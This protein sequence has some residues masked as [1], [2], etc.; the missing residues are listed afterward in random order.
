M[1]FEIGENVTGKAQTINKEII[2]YYFHFKGK[3]CIKKKC[4]KVHILQIIHAIFDFSGHSK[5]SWT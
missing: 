4:S 3:S 2:L 1:G 5:I